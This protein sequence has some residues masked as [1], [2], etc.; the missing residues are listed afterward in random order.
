[1]VHHSRSGTTATGIRAGVPTVTVPFF[2]DQHFWG[3][4][5]HRIRVAIKPIPRNRLS[6]GRLAQA[7][8][9]AVEDWEMAVRTAN[10][11]K[12][13]RVEDGVGSAVSMIERHYTN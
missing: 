5:V 6:A 13:V 7:I 8:T 10:L 11:E 3:R 9:Q 2:A 12:K 4:Q 1:M